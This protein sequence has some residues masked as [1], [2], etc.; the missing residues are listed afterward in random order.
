LLLC[1]HGGKFLLNFFPLFWNWFA[2]NLLLLK[3]WFFLKNFFI[4]F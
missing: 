3:A 1:W 2:I 4:S